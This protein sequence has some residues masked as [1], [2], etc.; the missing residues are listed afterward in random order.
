MIQRFKQLQQRMLQPDILFLCAIT[1]IGL[2]LRLW[3]IHYGL[4]YLYLE[5][6]EF[7]VQPALRVAE[8]AI[9]SGWYATPATTIIYPLALLFR[10]TNAVLNILQ[11]T[12]LTVSMQ[13]N[14][15]LTPFYIV[16]RVFMAIVGAT[17]IPLSYCLG[18]LWSKRAAVFS[19]ILVASSFYLVEHS[20]IIRPDILQ[21]VFTTS[22]VILLIK[23]LKQSTSEKKSLALYIL[24]GVAFALGVNTKFPA[25]FFAVPVVIAFTYLVLKKRAW[26]KGWFT[27][28][29]SLLVTS[30]LT[31][32]VLFLK[33]SKVLEG[34]QK[35]NAVEH[36]S[37]DGFTFIQKLHYYFIDTLHWEIGTL[38]YIIAIASLL[39]IFHRAYRSKQYIVNII[40]LS[41]ASYILLLSSLSLHWERWL[42]PVLPL[43]FVAA[44]I[45]ID[46]IY[47]FFKKRVN[48]YA[49]IALS[50]AVIVVLLTAPAIRLIK[51]I[52]AFSNSNAQDLARNWILETT[53]PDSKIIGEP[54]TPDMN[55]ADYT[56]TRVGSLTDVP[57]EELLDGRYSYALASH[58]VMDY[59]LNFSDE[60]NYQY[61]YISGIVKPRYKTL[62]KK[63]AGVISFPED[64]IHL[65]SSAV[66]KTDWEVM[67]DAFI[68]VYFGNK[69]SIFTLQ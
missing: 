61:D 14:Y 42:I 38:I 68:P 58:R 48:F 36:A 52:Y 20:H 33:F 21:T 62:S 41:I 53:P 63:S 5:D 11:D 31:A 49:R 65:Y 46:E 43:L 9:D 64:N 54:Y 51:T 22:V 37:H 6:E 17:L 40:W 56:Y 4:P 44:A 13:F 30:F 57:S 32:P 34:V 8:G 47:E 7:F 18:N 50:C 28:A 12:S 59:L 29:G 27:S 19:S 35:E 69:I 3:H 23:I 26:F 66:T 55:T 45:S 1:L 39:F 67:Q 24:L 25:A 16:G 10:I 15:N 60:S 2:S